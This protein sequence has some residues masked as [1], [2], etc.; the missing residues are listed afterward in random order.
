MFNSV[1]ISCNKS[2]YCILQARYL[3]VQVFLIVFMSAAYSEN[4]SIPSKNKETASI[5]EYVKHAMMFN[6]QTPQEKVY[7]HFDN[8]GY[9][10]GE[11]I[12]YKAYVIRTDNNHATDISKVLYVELINPSG[13]VV[14]T[15]KLPIENGTAKGDI[16]LDSILGTGFYE[17]RAYTRYMINW[18]GNGIFSRVFPV[19]RAPVTEG[20]YTKT[21]VDKISYKK[22]LPNIRVA[23][24]TI[25]TEGTKTQE[26]FSEQKGN[27]PTVHFYPEGGDL[28]KGLHSRVAF[29]VTD[30]FG[31]AFATSG[32]LEDGSGNHIT[33]VMTDSHGR[34]MFECTPNGQPFYL[35]VRDYKNK[36]YSF[37]IQ[38]PKDK[39]CVLYLDPI[40]DDSIRLTI[41]SS[42]NMHGKLLGYTLM[43]NGNIVECDTFTATPTFHKKYPRHNC[44]DGV[45]QLTVFDC[46]GQI[47]A[48]RL[49]FVAPVLHSDEDYI[50][51]K[52]TTEKLTPCGKVTLNIQSA[53]PIPGYHFRLWPKP[54]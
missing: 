51:V 24:D 1:F 7:L 43:H 20:D 4:D 26:I 2:M 13:D 11:R 12:W 29:T 10:K 38:Q 30:E 50:Q 18:G 5:I 14:E 53:P 6:A 32:T 27:K 9:F 23:D 28:V 35:S 36:K 15:Q 3:L 39:G 44:P 42:E 37:E 48:D 19:F 22:R 21:I 8:T 33:T 41:Y 40:R 46:R 25:T 52:N 34:G 54:Q 45:N 17:V 49:F 16:A 31:V 47:Y